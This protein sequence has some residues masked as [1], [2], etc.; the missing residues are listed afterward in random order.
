MALLRSVEN[1]F[2]AIFPSGCYYKFTVEGHSFSITQSDRSQK[3]LFANVLNLVGYEDTSE[4]TELWSVVKDDISDTY[5]LFKFVI[6]PILYRRRKLPITVLSRVSNKQVH[7]EQN[8][9]GLLFS[10]NGNGF[11]F[12]EGTSSPLTND[13]LSQTA[14]IT[15][16]RDFGSL[17]PVFIRFNVIGGEHTDTNNIKVFDSLCNLI[18]YNSSQ[19]TFGIWSVVS[20]G[21]ALIL[22][23]FAITTQN[24]DN[25]IRII[26]S[27][28]NTPQPVEICN[29]L[30]LEFKVGPNSFY[31]RRNSSEPYT[32]TNI[33]AP[34][35][36]DYG[37][38]HQWDSQMPAVT[39]AS[40]L[41]RICHLMTL[42]NPS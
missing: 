23:K 21:Q 34:D 29:F 33:P 37:T 7:L 26:D 11:Y 13:P 40:T 30:G 32:V 6:R 24:T 22:H 35:K 19:S 39:P 8:G 20:N 2:S 25:V 18:G 1:D 42:A 38:E 36:F 16:K 9:H 14:F 5:T 17:Y 27:L 10:V 41:A 12:N 31:F 28:I 4:R 3:T 15:M